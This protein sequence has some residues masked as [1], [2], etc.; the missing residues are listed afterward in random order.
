[1]S[2]L[3]NI[4]GPRAR[5]GEPLA[6]HTTWGL[7]GPAGCL[8]TARDAA[9][10]AAIVAACR[11]AGCPVK[12]LGRGSNLL[13]AGAGFPG[14]MLKLAGALAGLKASGRVIAAGGGA[15]L[16]AAVKLATRLGLSGLEWAAG[17]PGTVGGAIATNAGAHG[18]DMAAV[19]ARVTLLS[20]EGEVITLAG[21]DLPAAYR[22]RALP[23]GSLVL[24]AELA[25][26]IAAPATIAARV[27]ELL[28]QRKRTQPLGA[29]TAG[30][31]FRNPP[32]DFAGRLI[33]AAGLKGLAVGDA[34]VSPK[35]AN[36]IVNRGR[37]TAAEVLD[38]ME[39]VRRAVAERFGVELTPE[40]EVVGDV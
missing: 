23:A 32:G 24:G 27:A 37:A 10:A 25:L 38:L 40:V 13:V 16:N 33:E 1:M 9:E 22:R 36:F 5:F 31:V 12:A 14:V 35:H 34:V 18:A 8:A 39:A 3:A 20:A 17:I 30:S 11:A 29:K 19:A 4:L 26:A 28:A 21:A 7:G 2:A 6:A 15:S